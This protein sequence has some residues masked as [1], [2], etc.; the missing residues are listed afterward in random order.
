MQVL[1]PGQQA[2]LQSNGTFRLMPDT[3]TA[4]VTAWKNGMFAFNDADIASI[5]RQVN[6]WYDAEIVYTS[7]VSQHFVGS[8]PRDVPV[9]KL[10]TML[11]LT[12]RLRFR[13]EGKKIIV[14]QP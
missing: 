1:Q 7:A 3:D 11:E 4:A 14:T 9:S 6:R 2:Q 13:I 8:I 5:M 10:L 12:G